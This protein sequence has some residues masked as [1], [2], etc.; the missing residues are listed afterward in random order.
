MCVCVLYTTYVKGD[1]HKWEK[2]PMNVA[3]CQKRRVTMG[4]YALPPL[5]D[6]PMYKR[7]IH[8]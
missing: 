6:T 4:V 2:R 7:D 3:I 5:P 1:L 8:K